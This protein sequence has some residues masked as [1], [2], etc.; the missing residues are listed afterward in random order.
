M[1]LMYIRVAFVYHTSLSSPYDQVYSFGS[2]KGQLNIATP[3]S[4]NLQLN[5]HQGNNRL[6]LFNYGTCLVVPISSMILVP[7]G[8]RCMV[9]AGQWERA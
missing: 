4:S 6:S 5:G 2:P 7:G 1:G 3:C 8:D 9:A